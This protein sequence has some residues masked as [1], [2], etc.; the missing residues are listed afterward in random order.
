MANVVEEAVAEQNENIA[1]TVDEA[2]NQIAEN[3]GKEYKDIEEVT[4]KFGK[5][6]VGEPFTG[7]DGNEY[8]QIKIPNKDEADKTPWA[9]FVVKANAVHD[10]K[11]GK[12]KWCKLPADGSTT[13]TKPIFL[14]NDEN[15]K[16][17]WDNDKNKVSN[18]EL[19]SMVE[20][21]KE[22]PREQ[23]AEVA[24]KKPSLK[25]KMEEKKEDVKAKK[26]KE[27]APKAKSKE[28]SL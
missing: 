21:Y 3:A 15:G 13:V 26:P 19:K 9:S 25:D 12:G 17:Q 27:K 7:K 24:D 6:L 8:R 11:F 22:R 2:M 18:K 10:D 4:L 14:G 16:P 23:E 20:F 5:G 1:Q 28:E